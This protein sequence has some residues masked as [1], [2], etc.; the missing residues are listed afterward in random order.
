MKLHI[1]NENCICAGRSVPC[2]I[3]DNCDD[4]DDGMHDWTTFEGTPEELRDLAESR[5]AGHPCSSYLYRTRATIL[6]AVYFERPDLEPTVE[7]VDEE[8]E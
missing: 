2:E 8:G 4:P 5:I 1:Y 7:E 6:N 3:I